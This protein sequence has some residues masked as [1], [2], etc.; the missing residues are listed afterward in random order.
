MLLERVDYDHKWSNQIHEIFSHYFFSSNYELACIIIVILWRRLQLLALCNHICTNCLCY[1]CQCSNTLHLLL[2]IQAL[3]L[4]W[5]LLTDSTEDVCFFLSKI[6]SFQQN[7]LFSVT[8]EV[9]VVLL[10]IN[11]ILSCNRFIMWFF[12]N[13]FSMSGNQHVLSDLFKFAFF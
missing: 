12:S 4:L 3:L 11:L 13:I 2:Y 9:R 1:N 10:K 7:W 5:S 6:F 8:P